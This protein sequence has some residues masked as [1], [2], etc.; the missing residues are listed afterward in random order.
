MRGHTDSPMTTPPA[1]P[2]RSFSPVVAVLALLGVLFVARLVVGLIMSL[3]MV[4]GVVA[5]LV[6]AFSLGSRRGGR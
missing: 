6:L 4:A 2:P 1:R 5:L 3:L